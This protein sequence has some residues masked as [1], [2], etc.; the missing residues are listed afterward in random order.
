MTTN[1]R[2]EHRINASLEILSELTTNME[3]IVSE[4][5][6]AK[7]DAIPASLRRKLARIDREYEQR[8]NPVKVRI[9]TVSAN[10]RTDTV[11]YGESVK[12]AGYHAVYAGGRI[13]WNTVGLNGYAVAHPEVNEFRKDSGPY[14]TI[15]KDQA[16]S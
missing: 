1:I 8:L 6:K 3:K 15:R 13:T 9:E 11:S 16:K 14:V 12:N 4:L 10:I 5:E 7:Y 2:L